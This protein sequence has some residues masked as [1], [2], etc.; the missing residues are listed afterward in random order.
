M[1]A[2]S[3]TKHDSQKVLKI[4]E[5]EKPTPKKNDTNRSDTKSLRT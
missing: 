1:K 4:Q 2:I 3:C 5:V